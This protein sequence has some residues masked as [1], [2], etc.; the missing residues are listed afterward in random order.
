MSLKPPTPRD[1]FLFWMLVYFFVAALLA[2]MLDLATHRLLSVHGDVGGIVFQLATLLSPIWGV[3]AWRSTRAKPENA[4]RG[5]NLQEALDPSAESSYVEDPRKEDSMQFVYEGDSGS[6]IV[7]W[8]NERLRAIGS[9]GNNGFPEAC[10]TLIYSGIDT[11]GLLAAPPATVDA[12]GE[13]F[14]DWCERY[15]LTRLRSIEGSSLTADDLWGARCG[16]LHT[17]TPVSTRSRIG[18][19]RE[20][21]YEFQGNVGVNLMANTRL[22][23]LVLTIEDLAKA[24]KEGGMAFIAD[25]GQD[26][27]S[28]QAA[29]SRAGSFLRWGTRG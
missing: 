27:T 12:T 22:K 3:Y 25:L 13:T 26:Q 16:V 18:S 19:A 28:L 29:E 4:Q 11:L 5:G 9:C 20:I 24:F 21:Y 8:F 10:L 7:A 17:S 2:V 1:L 6:R 15:L 14:Q 23:P